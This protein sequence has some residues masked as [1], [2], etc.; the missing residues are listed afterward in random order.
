MREKHEARLGYLRECMRVN[1]MLVLPV[2][3]QAH[4]TVLS[5]R[6]VG[7]SFEARYH[8]RRP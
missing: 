7:A 4:F 5:V 8:W 3:E 2:C 6:K 1:E